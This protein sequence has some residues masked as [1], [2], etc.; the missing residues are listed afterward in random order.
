[1]T[2]MVLERRRRLHPRLFRLLE[3]RQR[4][5][6]LLRHARQRADGPEIKRLVGLKARA[7]QLIHR[8]TATP[9]FS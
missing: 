1:M 8:F 9:A 5:D 2:H 6:A 4:I 3:T 7:R